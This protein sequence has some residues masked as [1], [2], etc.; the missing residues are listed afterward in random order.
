MKSNY[1]EKTKVEY[2]YGKIGGH[3]LY[4]QQNPVALG[5]LICFRG[6]SFTGNKSAIRSAL[7]WAKMLLQCRFI[8]QI[9]NSVQDLPVR[10]NLC[11]RVYNGWKVFDLKRNVVT[12]LFSTEVDQVEIE[13]EI[14]RVRRVGKHGFAPS[15][16]QSRVKERWYEEEYINGRNVIPKDWVGFLDIFQQYLLPCVESMILTHDPEYVNVNEYA[17]ERKGVLMGEKL[18]NQKLDNT[19][20]DSIRTF[21]NLMGEQLNQHTAIRIPLVFS[22]GDFK[23][24]H[25]LK[26]KRGPVIIDW[27]T[28]GR[29]S[30]LFDFY[31]AFFQP[32]Y[33]ERRATTIKSDI[34]TGISNLESR[35]RIVSPEL[36]SS[37]MPLEQIYR[38]LYYVERLAR[39]VE[40][41]SVITDDLLDSMLKWIGTFQQIER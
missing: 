4:L 31:N 36:S 14:E 12:K 16:L 27:E 34:N 28:V 26:A 1:C 35:L 13:E 32:V 37:L 25:V 9:N 19:K 24:S 15:I 40:A 41:F 38:Q 20:I 11:S 22:H 33:H 23:A 17:C 5:F 8:R 7:A 6:R 39:I 10:G 18:S 2:S 3:Y 29:R 21:V 30:L